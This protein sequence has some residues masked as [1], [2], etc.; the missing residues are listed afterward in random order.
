VSIESRTVVIGVPCFNEASRIEALGRALARLH[1]A[2][3]GLLAVDDGSTDGTGSALEAAGFEVITH[4]VNAGLGIARNSLWRRADERGFQAVAFLDADVEPPRDYLRRVCEVLAEGGVSGVGG[5]NIDSDEDWVDAWRGRFFPQSLGDRDLIDAPM[6]VGACS[7]YRV[8]ALRDVGGFSPRFRTH[9]ED[10]DMGR[11][12][13][14]GGHRLRYDPSIVVRHHRTDSPK[15]LV[16]NCYHHCREG[17][18]ATLATRGQEPGPPDLV[19][20]MMRKALRAPAAA[21]VRRQDPREAALGVAACG[22]ALAGYAAGL[23]RPR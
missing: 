10:V 8:A 23:L 11:R 15:S 20:G 12:L 14:A 1:P 9:G 13:R 3:G 18:R 6:L 22:A 21:L 5:R 19:F 17:M 4:E 2:P 16:R 7:T